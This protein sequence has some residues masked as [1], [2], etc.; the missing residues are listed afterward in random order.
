M[1][2]NP[3]MQRWINIQ[4]L[5]NVI[6]YLN[7]LNKNYVIIP[8][9]AEKAFEQFQHPFI[10]KTLNQVVVEKAYL[11]I[12][13]GMYGKSTVN[14]MLNSE[15]LKTLCLRSGAR[16]GCLLSITVFEYII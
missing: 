9:D 15:K 1:G 2:I 4:K 14:I 8:G 11:N 5:I 16:Q 13:K 7:K 12:I 10:K 3:L 6:H